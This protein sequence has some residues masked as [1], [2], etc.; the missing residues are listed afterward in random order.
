MRKFTTFD[1]MSLQQLKD[2]L[3][4]IVWEQ[5]HKRRMTIKEFHEF[6]GISEGTIKQ[7]EKGKGNPTLKTISILAEKFKMEIEDLLCFDNYK[8]GK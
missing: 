6:L 4:D 7:L 3:A 1:K 8:K 5:R 2:E